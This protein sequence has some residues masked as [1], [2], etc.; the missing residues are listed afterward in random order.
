MRLKRSEK[1]R[2]VLNSVCEITETKKQ[3]ILSIRKTSD[4]CWARNLLILCL[5]KEGLKPVTIQNLLHKAG[6]SGVGHS[7]VLK[8][9]E[10]AKVLEEKNEEFKAILD[11]ITQSI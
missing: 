2:Q 3:D 1:F 6:W 10:R 11:E 9:I 8:N 7:T 5:K 4:V